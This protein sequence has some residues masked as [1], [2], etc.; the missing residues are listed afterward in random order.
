MGSSINLPQNGTKTLKLRLS[1]TPDSSKAVAGGS[2]AKKNGKQGVIGQ[3]GGHKHKSNKSK[4]VNHHAQNSLRGAP[5][6][7]EVKQNNLWQ[8]EDSQPE[9]SAQLQCM[10]IRNNLSLPTATVASSGSPGRQTA[11]VPTVP[12][13][14]PPHVARLSMADHR[15]LT[16]IVQRNMEQH[17]RNS[18]SHKNSRYVYPPP[19]GTRPLV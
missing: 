17:R 1:V 13:A 9:K 2:Q 10:D 19:P 16:E 3:S 18:K 14:V 5:T 12:P 4:N 8:G 6:Q 11:P 15:Q 7:K